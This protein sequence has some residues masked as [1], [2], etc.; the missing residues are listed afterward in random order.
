VHVEEVLAAGGEVEVGDRPYLEEAL[1]G[2]GGRTLGSEDAR[3]QE[4]R[5]E[6]R[7]ME[8]RDRAHGDGFGVRVGAST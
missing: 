2:R 1:H 8:L 7:E 3:G 5:S 4:E 6:D